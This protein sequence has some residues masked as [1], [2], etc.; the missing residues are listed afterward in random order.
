[1]VNGV[2]LCEYIAKKCKLK[3]SISIASK[4]PGLPPLFTSKNSTKREGKSGKGLTIYDIID[5]C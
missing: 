1:M 3:F 2:V 4:F 5:L